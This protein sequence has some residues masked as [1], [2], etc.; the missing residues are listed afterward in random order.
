M[1]KK[2]QFKINVAMVATTLLLI[3]SAVPRTLAQGALPCPPPQLENVVNT[4]EKCSCFYSLVGSGLDLGNSATFSSVFNDDSVQN[5]AQTGQYTGVDGIAEYYSFV[6]KGGGVDG[7]GFIKDYILIGQPL[8]LDMSGTTMEQCVAT[9]AERRRLPF[10][11]FFARDNQEICVDIVVGSTLYYIMNDDPTSPI[12]VQ[13]VNT[14]FP[15]EMASGTF[16]YFIDT[17][18]TSEFIC[19]TIVNTCGEDNQ[20]KRKLPK[21]SKKS[22]ASKKQ[23]KAPKKSKAMKKCMRRYSALPSFDAGSLSYVDGNSKGCRV[24]HS[25]FARTNPL[26]CPH[27]SFEAEE[28]TNGIF[29]CNESKQTILTDLFSEQQLGLFAYAG[30]LLGLPNSIDIKFEACPGF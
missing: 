28:D 19:D 15:D 8:F 16:S 30:T 23:T 6:K 13:K 21:K 12:T 24:L 22:K 26:H 1:I 2:K 18:A 11:S 27:V 17:P 7:T 4:K 25:V 14:W 5:F 29:K 9:V 3:S 20:F 10:N